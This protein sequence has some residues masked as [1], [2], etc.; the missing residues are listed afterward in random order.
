MTERQRGTSA[1][2]TR[3]SL[4]ETTDS[5]HRTAAELEET[6]AALHRSAEAS[7]DRRTCDR[8]HRLGDAVTAE[9]KNIDRR[10]DKLTPHFL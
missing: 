1:S 10:A 3:A 2:D 7:P 4:R 6:E 5:M 9:A 8:L